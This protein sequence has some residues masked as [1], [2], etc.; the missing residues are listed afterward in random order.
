MRRPN[1]WRAVQQ[2][3]GNREEEAGVQLQTVTNEQRALRETMKRGGFPV[4]Y[5]AM[6]A[7][8]NPQVPQGFALPI[9]CDNAGNLIMAPPGRPGTDRSHWNNAFRTFY[10][11]EV[12][13]RL[14]AM[15]NNAALD[16]QE[17]AQEAL[18]NG[19]PLVPIAP[20][21]P[22]APLV[23]I[24]PEEAPQAAGQPMG[25][26]A[27]EIEISMPFAREFAE[28]TYE[29]QVEAIDMQMGLLHVHQKVRLLSA[30][31]QRYLD[32]TIREHR[33]VDA[34]LAALENKREE[35]SPEELDEFMRDVFVDQDFENSVDDAMASNGGAGPSWYGGAGPSWYGGAGQANQEGCRSCSADASPPQVYRSCA[36]PDEGAPPAV[37]R[38]LPDASP[39]QVYRSCAAPDEGAPP[40]ALRS[41]PPSQSPSSLTLRQKIARLMLARLY[42]GIQPGPKRKQR[43]P[44]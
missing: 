14:D 34:T 10:E 36:A 18:A 7:W 39:P 15:G 23:P 32:P 40:A 12:Q 3:V 25:L 2:I 22:I 35:P 28:T 37:L 27:P 19:A 8:F 41:L 4:Q 1:A 43:K 21:L 17:E 24:A 16:A 26:G 38:S 44:S 9:Y 33:A 6:C 13:P 5:Q 29:Q 30:L 20:L 11:D 31:L 42:R